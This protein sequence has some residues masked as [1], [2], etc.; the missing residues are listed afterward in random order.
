MLQLRR[1]SALLGILLHR[2]GRNNRQDSCRNRRRGRALYDG[3]VIHAEIR[4]R[5]VVIKKNAGH[6]VNVYIV[7]FERPA[8]PSR[9]YNPESHANVAKMAILRIRN[10]RCLLG[11]I[12]LCGRHE[13][14]TAAHGSAAL[15]RKVHD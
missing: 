15:P 8:T 3:S 5:V 9:G 11:S 1:V 12:P 10:G 7:Y 13:W 2:N 14:P 4:S 6:G